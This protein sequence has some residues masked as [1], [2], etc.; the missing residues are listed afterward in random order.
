MNSPNKRHPLALQILHASWIVFLTITLLPACSSQDSSVA[1]TPTSQNI[2]EPTPTPTATLPP[3]DGT[4]LFEEGR[5]KRDEICGR[6]FDYTQ[7]TYGPLTIAIAKNFTKP[8][9]PQALA[10]QVIERYNDLAESSPV[11][12]D[13][14]VTIYIIPDPMNGECY[15]RDQIIF[16]E[17]EGIDSRTFVEDVLGAAADIHE[18]WVKTGLASLTLGEQPDHEALNTWYQDPEYLDMTGLFIAWFTEEWTTE[19]ERELAHMSATSLVQYALE[20]E[21][22]S[23]TGLVEQVNN[24]VRTRWLESLGVD[25][26][27]TYPYDGRFAGFKYS[28]D[29]GC[30]LVVQTDF[31]RYC[32]NRLPP[33]QGLFQK[34]SEVEFFID[35]TYYGRKALVEYVMTEAP[36]VKNTMKPDEIIEFKVTKLVVALGSARGN[37]IT[38]QNSAVFYYPLHEIVHTFDW[39]MAFPQANFWLMEGFAEYLGKLLP[40]YPQTQKRCIFWDLS[41]YTIDLDISGLPEDLTYCYRLDSEQFEAAKAWYLAQ[42]GL[43]DNSEVVDVRLFS[44]AFAF[45]TMYR[46]AY[47]GTLGTPIGEKYQ[48]GPNSKLASL[49]GLELS[50]TQAASMIAWLCDTY[51]LDRVLDVYING[52]EDGLLD[53]KTYA[54]LKAS[55]QADLASKGQGIPIPGA[56]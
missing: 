32:L 55:W 25:Q 40:I 20:V 50:Y 44:D 22:I 27:V 41:G 36:S 5:Y 43:T 37:S 38:L 6:I 48:I 4:L 26:E 51:T 10:I 1:S 34:V 7:T 31:I 29:N 30:A 21:R 13:Q 15:S 18:Y 39:N 17:P 8:Q 3:L 53:G 9:D 52:A 42:G 56:P 54:E 47:P 12:L 45:A 16:S 23:P 2:A 49:D 33:E 24:A 35:Y 14:P 46:N 19:Q 28:T 11:P